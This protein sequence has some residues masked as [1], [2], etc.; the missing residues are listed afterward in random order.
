MHWTHQSD[1]QTQG[2]GCPLAIGFTFECTWFHS[3]GALGTV[4]CGFHVPIFGFPRF[5]VE[6]TCV[7]CQ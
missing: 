7:A 4:G 3:L 1:V 5:V 6:R 2:N